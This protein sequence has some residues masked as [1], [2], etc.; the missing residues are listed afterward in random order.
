VSPASS[1][2]HPPLPL[3]AGLPFGI[4]F[5]EMASISGL[6]GTVLEAL[7]CGT[8]LA[9]AAYLLLLRLPA[10]SFLDFHCPVLRTLTRLCV[11]TCVLVGLA[12][13]LD[14]W[15]SALSN[16][17]RSSE[18]HTASALRQV[19][20]SYTVRLVS[21]AF[22]A[23][24]VWRALGERSRLESA[25]LV[26]SGV[27]VLI[28]VR[29]LLLFHDVLPAMWSMPKAAPSFGYL[30]FPWLY[31]SVAGFAVRLM[32]PGRSASRGRTLLFL[33][34]L[35]VASAMCAMVSH[36]WVLRLRMNGG[37]L[38]GGPVGLV[39]AAFFG[40]DSLDKMYDGSAL[41]L[42]LAGLGAVMVFL[43]VLRFVFR[44]PFPRITTAA[45]ALAAW[46]GWPSSVGNAPFYALFSAALGLAALL[47]VTA[48]AAANRAPGVWGERVAA[49]AGL[50]CGVWAWRTGHLYFGFIPFVVSASLAAL[51]LIG[52]RQ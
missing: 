21:G 39:R 33:A 37:G 31:L 42:I 47:G 1:L 45:L 13:T 5:F 41:L 10:T 12:I 30:S 2:R 3:I 25:V 32:P 38:T 4:P 50:A 36:A 26:L 6:G 27:A 48:V 20:G 17:L 23:W 43:Y 29:A 14:G 8:L 40:R 35:T 49:S 28:L 19:A 46:M 16:W 9:L 22:L 24:A 11:L 51:A 15:E 34:A 18:S 52:R 7:L 44:W